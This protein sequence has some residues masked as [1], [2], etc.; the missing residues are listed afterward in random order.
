MRNL[1][2]SLTLRALISQEIPLD[3]PLPVI[4]T[5]NCVCFCGPLNM[6][7]II[8]VGWHIWFVT[9]TSSWANCTN[10][11]SVKNLAWFSAIPQHVPCSETMIDSGVY[12]LRGRN[13]VTRFCHESILSRYF[14]L[15]LP[16][17]LLNP[18]DQ[19]EEL[20]STL[21]MQTHLLT[22]RNCNVV[23]CRLMRGI[24]VGS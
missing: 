3:F 1:R 4:V 7:T 20:P 8:F 6:G 9:N 19:N 5:Q 14:S 2:G 18:N 24:P 11:C 15:F 12:V 22:K 17:L 16:N 13:G 21:G 23:W 10:F